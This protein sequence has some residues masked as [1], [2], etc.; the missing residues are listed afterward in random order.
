MLSPVHIFF[1]YFSSLY[2][3]SSGTRLS[4]ARQAGLSLQRQGK[5]ISNSLSK[6]TALEMF[7]T[8]ILPK[9]PAV[10]NRKVPGAIRW[11]IQMSK[12]IHSPLQMQAHILFLSH[13]R[14]MQDV[15]CQFRL[16]KSLSKCCIVV[17]PHVFSL[18]KP[19]I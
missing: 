8:S 4:A 13:Q 3:S 19:E 7:W 12:T 5:T 18:Q 17:T 14:E 1:I 2:Q 6:L 10:K 16:S 11:A 9:K 15:H